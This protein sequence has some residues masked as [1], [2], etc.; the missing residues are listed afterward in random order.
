[1]PEQGGTMVNSTLR[2]S[3]DRIQL[4][5]HD[6]T[7][8]LIMGVLAACGLIYEYLLS[9]YAGRILGAVETAIY[10]MIGLMIVSMGLG[11]LAARVIKD[12]FTAFA[13]LEVVI[14]ILGITCILIIAALV[15]LTSLLPQ[16]VVD[17]FLLPP[18]LLP[19]GGFFA[20]LKKLAVASPYLFGFVLGFL[21]GME[22]PLIARVREELHGIHLMHNIGTIYGADYIGAG[23]GAVIWVAIM[24]SMDVT[25]AAVL[26]AL[27]NLLAGLLFLW[28]YWSRI[29]YST[30]LLGF[31]V[32]ILILAFAVHR[33]GEDWASSMTNLLYRD[34]VVFDQNT[35]YQHLTI[36]QRVLSGD[37]EPVYGF[38]ING[39]LQFSSHDE[40][41]YHAMLV[42][43]T[44]LVAER[45]EK[46]LIIGGGD[47]LAL[48][49]V[50]KWDPTQVDVIDL[51]QQ[52]IEFFSAEEG[53]N[54]PYY[55]RALWQL[56]ERAF[57]DERVKLRYGDA[58]LEIDRLLEQGELYD[59]IIIDLP[60]P[61]HPDLNR[62]YSV[63]FYARLGHLL[64]GGGAMALQSTS[65]YH[66]KKAFLSIGRTV[67]EAGFRNVQQY[68]QNV[69]SFGEWGW[70]IA[71]KLGQ[72]PRQRISAID[73][74]PLHDGWISKGLMLAAFEFPVGFFDDLDGI[75]INYLGSNRIYQYHQ[76]AWQQEQG[77][78]QK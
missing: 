53:A 56:N 27:A 43:P 71:T 5:L 69:P 76:Q 24:L 78:Y 65:P 36:T 39:R 28:R 66:A 49:D 26:T 19:G 67:Q 60:D 58:F 59:V 72:T 46:I 2:E 47:G 61:G 70:T 21:I 74:L 11:S 18:D 45:T 23:I 9:H 52:V 77:I 38:Y 10:A 48:R 68:R 55:Q 20:A 17:T 13:W 29:G 51:D 16:V 3:P 42:Y 50:L 31:H 64:T 12:P 37:I 6:G 54:P 41:I 15:A 7:L 8:I 25:Q 63:N 73:E 44:M 32:L 40:H 75:E 4:L 35:P 57:S 14:A 22:I 33:S 1:L 62:L 30:L 34:Q